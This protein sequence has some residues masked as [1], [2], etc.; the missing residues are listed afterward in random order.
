MPGVTTC[1]RSEEWT[2]LADSNRRDSRLQ[3][4]KSFCRRI[5]MLGKLQRN[6]KNRALKRILKP[7]LPVLNSNAEFFRSQFPRRVSHRV[8]GLAAPLQGSRRGAAFGFVALR[9]AFWEAFS[10]KSLDCLWTTLKNAR[11]WRTPTGETH[12]SKPKNFIVG[13]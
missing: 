8:P 1:D 10:G 6:K 11:S 9:G 2:F 12:A 13:G 3:T 7:R 5:D 4:G